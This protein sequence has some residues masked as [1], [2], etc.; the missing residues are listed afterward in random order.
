MS[1]VVRSPYR[2]A[3]RELIA[4]LI[5]AGYLRPIQRNNADAVTKAIL[6][7]KRNLRDPHDARVDYDK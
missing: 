5:K 6:L 2:L 7:M 3:S 1:N 4:K